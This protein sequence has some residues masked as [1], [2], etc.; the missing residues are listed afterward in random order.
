[1]GII[2]SVIIGVGAAFVG[3]ATAGTVVGTIAT[4]TAIC[5]GIAA[6]SNAVSGKN[7]FQISTEFQI[8]MGNGPA[9]FSSRTV[10]EV[11]PKNETVLLYDAR[12]KNHTSLL[13]NAPTDGTLPTSLIDVDTNK[14][15]KFMPTSYLPKITFDTK[16]Q[17][18]FSLSSPVSLSL[19]DD[20]SI[21][22]EK[23]VQKPFSFSTHGSDF[24]NKLL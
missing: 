14:K 18:L 7:N 8:G 23:Y 5:T 19:F 4:S 21:N 24:Y 16:S 13:R 9:E 17:S 12:N 3:A 6:V 11:L 20:F 2:E 10:N 1:M 22:T 15:Y